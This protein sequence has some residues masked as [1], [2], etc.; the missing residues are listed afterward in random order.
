M[1]FANNCLQISCFFGSVSSQKLC[2][3]YMNDINT[4]CFPWNGARTAIYIT[5]DIKRLGYI[6]SIGFAMNPNTK[7]S[8]CIGSLK[9][10]EWQCLKMHGSVNVPILLQGLGCDV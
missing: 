5:T 9:G 7:P 3:I 2:I 1:S 8:E 4:R 6:N 10:T